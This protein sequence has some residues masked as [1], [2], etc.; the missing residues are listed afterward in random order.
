MDLSL[1]GKAALV[2]A[3]SKGLGRAAALALA[4]EGAKV[5]ICARGPETLAHTAEEIRN[6]TGADVLPIVADV[7]GKEDAARLVS[8]AVQRFGGLDILV[9]NAGGPKS[10]PFSSLSEEDWR[11]AVDELLLSVVRLCAEVVPHLKRRG[12]GRI[13]H[14]TSVSV[15]QPVENLMLSNSIRAAVVG[16]AKTLANELAPDRILVNCVAPGYTRTDRVLELLRAGARQEGV[17]PAEIERRLVGQIPL[18]RMGE[19]DEFGAVVA[20]LAS[21]RASFITGSV[22]PI[23]GG[24]VKG[25]L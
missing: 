13:I 4:R 23:D 15:K 11:Q 20:F 10:G 12:G 25:L 16:F 22:I 3:A 7:A 9:T 19:P 1:T 2:C 21:E 8:E 24:F 6:A 18:G 17:D 14:V 5:A